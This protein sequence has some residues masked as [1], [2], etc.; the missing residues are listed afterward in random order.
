MYAVIENGG[1]QYRVE[2]GAELELDQL[3]ADPGHEQEG[4]DGDQG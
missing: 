2:L 3:A 4:D 1:K